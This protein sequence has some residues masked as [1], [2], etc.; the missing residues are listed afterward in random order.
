VT[1]HS[2]ATTRALD[3]IERLDLKLIVDRTAKEYGWTEYQADE[4]EDWYKNFL[5][6][7]YLNRRKPVAAL[8]RD[9]DILWHQHIL[10]TVRYQRDCKALFGHY[11]NH[12]PIEG[13]PS[14]AELRAIERSKKQ[15]LKEFGA[16]PVAYGARCLK[17]P[18]HPHPPKRRRSSR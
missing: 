11:L 4:A 18:P 17:I 10:N 6:L 3:K 14:P 8:G 2:K 12:E 5:K 7:C 16:I 9:A 1:Q 13:R 15:Y